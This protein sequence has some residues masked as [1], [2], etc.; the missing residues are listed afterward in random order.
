MNKLEKTSF[1]SYWLMRYL[2]EY[3][4]TIKNLSHNT[5]SSYRDCYKQYLP[6]IAKKAGKH[7]DKLLITDITVDRTT[8]FLNY[9]EKEKA[10]SIKT[11]NHR[12]SA[13][14]AF[15]HYVS[16]NAPE[17]ME[18]SRLMN[19]IPIK[20]DKIKI[21]EG[22]VLPD[23]TYLDKNEMD[24]LLNAPDQRTKQ[25]RKDYAILLF[26]YNTGTRA[27]EAA[28][29]TIGSIIYDN[30]SCP[31]VRI[32]GKGNKSRTCPLWDKTLNAIKPLILGR[33]D[34]ERVFINRYGNPITRF[35]I[36]E[37]LKRNVAKAVAYFPTMARK[38]V[39][40]HTLRQYVEYHNMG[41]EE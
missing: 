1:V 30:A 12:L 27:S 37:L 40:P 6:F 21:V 16:S 22:C 9:I 4:P 33:H 17:Y 25:G 15:V 5:L 2:S 20:K 18:W 7:A 35:G 8:E 3:M 24:A 19:A 29:L 26:L 38:N 23:V 28:S 10:C 36:Y 41:S 11:R 14:K 39:S 31:L 32:Y 13:I 34:T